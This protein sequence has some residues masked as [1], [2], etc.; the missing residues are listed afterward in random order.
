LMDRHHT[1]LSVSI[2]GRLHQAVCGMLICF[3]SNSARVVIIPFALPDLRLLLEREF[4]K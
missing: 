1:H 4:G 3:N 2:E